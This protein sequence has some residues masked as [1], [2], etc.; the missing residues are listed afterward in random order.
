[1]GKRA[2]VTIELGNALGQ[3]GD[4]HLT[5][6]ARLANAERDHWPEPLSLD[7][8]L[9]ADGARVEASYA[10]G[11]G[12][13]LW[14]EFH[15]ALYALT[16]ELDATIDGEHHNDRYSTSFGLREIGRD[17]SQLT[18]NGRKLFL[19]GTL[20]CCIF[21]LTGY[22]PTDLAAW[23]RIIG[24]CQ[25]H[26]LN[27][28]RFH[29]W[30]PPE[31]AF[32][33]AD[34]LGFYYQVECASWANQGATIGEGGPLDGW[35]YEEGRRINAVYGNHPSF[36]MM[37]YGN[38]P[39][40]KHEEY[41]ARWV[42]YWKEHEPRRVHTSGA[43]WPAIPEN[44]YH[45]IPAPRIHAWG[46][47]LTSRINARP[48]ETLT[49][50]SDYVEQ[51]SAPIVSHEIGQWCVFPNFDEIAKYTG[52]LKP[53]NFEIFRNLLEANHMGDQA[54]DFLMASGKL[55]AL[56]YKEEIESALRTPGFGGFQLLDLHDFPGQGTALVGVLDPFWDSKGYISAAEH[57]RFCNSTV[58]LARLSKRYW[59]TVETFR[60]DIDI[61]HFGPT[62][63]DGTVRWR[64]VDDRGVALAQ[65]A[66]PHTTIQI[67]N[68]Q[69]LGAV[70]ADLSNFA[71]AQKY[72]L[73][74]SI[75]GSEFEND[76]EIWVFADQLDSA[77]PD[78]ILIV[79][80][81]NEAALARLSDGGKVMLMPP[82]DSVATESVLGFSSVFWNT[83]WTNNQAPHTL[84]IL[85][86]PG[87]PALADF[88]TEYHSN[89]QWWELVHGAAAMTLDGLPPTLRPLVQPIDTWFE[90][91]RLG[92]LFEAKVGGGKLLVCSMDLHSDLDQR[93]V[94]R[95]M[96]HSLL[97]YMRGEAFDPREEVEVQAIRGLLR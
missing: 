41:L 91:R 68:G 5:L 22:P 94:A 71:P 1:V 88:P 70:E 40:G 17:G 84:G 56:C 50:Y 72:R 35:L 23:K 76:W 79:E 89:W 9:G 82:A 62:P 87:H 18:I 78:E 92:L 25:A 45:N 36:L 13:Q 44:D 24:I 95:Q 16:V 73:V 47:G 60:A 48:P 3:A 86:D 52:V 12:A 55:Q 31:V 80:R 34:E 77:T 30:C 39:A 43:G 4:A 61:A 21:P 20:E 38:E 85:C 10:L 49:D 81:L 42:A 83:A 74:V 58:P 53:K 69:R 6:Q 65:G 66:L 63:L 37:A 32:V 26:G 90:S 33:A 75:E 19:R 64:L 28:I 7:I 51:M 29:S 15:P 2:R 11:D 8:D 14:D 97:R 96:R 27:H 67:G 54:H 57:R 93:L 46:A 59:R